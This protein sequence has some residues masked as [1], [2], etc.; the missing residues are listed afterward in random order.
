MTAAPARPRAST[1]APA[2]LDYRVRRPSVR[3]QWAS[4][5]RPRIGSAFAEFGAPLAHPGGRVVD[6]LDLDAFGL[7]RL[8]LGTGYEQIEAAGAILV[9]A[10]MRSIAVVEPAAS[11]QLDRLS[12]SS[13]SLARTA[14]VSSSRSSPG[15]LASLAMAHP[16]LGSAPV[17][18]T[19][20]LWRCAGQIGDQ[21]RRSRPSRIRSSPNAN[22]TSSSQRPRTPSW[23]T[24]IASSVTRG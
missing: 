5:C 24:D 11:D 4:L 3:C 16:L 9:S 6:D 20:R 19:V 18:V 23:L 8:D 10:E 13:V 15:G 21:R 1:A 22:S 2:R 17:G 7:E 12:Q 14:N